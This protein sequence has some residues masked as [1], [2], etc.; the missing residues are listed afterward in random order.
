[1]STLPELINVNIDMLFTLDIDVFLTA[2]FK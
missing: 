2:I 1:M